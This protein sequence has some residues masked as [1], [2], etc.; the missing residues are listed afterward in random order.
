MLPAN[1]CRRHAKVLFL[2]SQLYFAQVIGQK[3]NVTVA[4]PPSFFSVIFTPP[5][6]FPWFWPK[7]T[8]YIWR[9]Q[10]VRVLS[11]YFR[12][13][14]SYFRVSSAWSAEIFVKIMHFL[15]FRRKTT[16]T[17]YVL[18][19]YEDDTQTTC[20]HHVQKRCVWGRGESF[21]FCI[22]SWKKAW[23]SVLPANVCRRHAKERWRHIKA[24]ILREFFSTRVFS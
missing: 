3:K 18:P 20:R 5:N 8:R 7:F 6:C 15:G 2:Q 14:S 4:P 22:K 13:S 23:F 16:V 11:S 12:V 24:H 17:F 21:Y 10:V 19:K 1:E 9:R